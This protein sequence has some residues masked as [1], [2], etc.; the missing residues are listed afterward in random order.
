MRITDAHMERINEILRNVSDEDKT[1]D[2]QHGLYVV[3]D[4]LEEEGISQHELS[5]YIS[6]NGEFLINRALLAEIVG[7]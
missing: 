2:P 4:Y 6:E 7:L 5:Q 3:W 1:K